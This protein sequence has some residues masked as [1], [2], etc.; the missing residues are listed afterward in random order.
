MS[1]PGSP[2]R[3]VLTGP[4]HLKCT[5]TPG[6][7]AV[8][9]LLHACGKE[10]QADNLNAQV[11]SLC[12]GHSQGFWN[13]L[14]HTDWLAACGI[15]VCFEATVCLFVGKGLAG[16]ELDRRLTSTASYLQ[17]DFCDSPQH[18]RVYRCNKNN[19]T[20]S[21]SS[22]PLRSQ[23]IAPG[24]QPSKRNSCAAH[25]APLLAHDVE[26]TVKWLQPESSGLPDEL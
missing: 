26:L 17:T 11:L 21:V 25:S 8:K 9:D 3:A 16:M 5:R 6:N 20:N 15:C 13:C 18:L 4:H 23:C 24:M 12:C 7:Q 14:L 10:M 2:Q 19:T 1:P 22:W